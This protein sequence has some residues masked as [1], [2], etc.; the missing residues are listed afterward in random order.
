[1]KVINYLN[2]RRSFVFKL[3]FYEFQTLLVLFFRNVCLRFV[4]IDS[5]GHPLCLWLKSFNVRCRPAELSQ[6]LRGILISSRFLLK[7]TSLLRK[8][9]NRKAL[10]RSKRLPVLKIA[11]HTISQR[12]LLLHFQTFYT[13]KLTHLVSVFE[14]LIKSYMKLKTKL[15]S[16][17]F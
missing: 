15:T 1:M 9:N 8:Q 17:C 2:M 4:E 3:L 16:L 7:R 14:R 10:L 13:V 12:V 6:R 11:F 5:V